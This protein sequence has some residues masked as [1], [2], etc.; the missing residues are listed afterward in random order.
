MKNIPILASFFFGLT[1]VWCLHM[2]F[3]TWWFPTY[4]FIREKLSS[5]ALQSNH[6]LY[7][8]SRCLLSQATCVLL[9]IAPNS[10]SEPGRQLIPFNPFW[11][12][13]NPG[14]D[15]RRGELFF[16]LFCFEINQHCLQHALSIFLCAFKEERRTEIDWQKLTGMFLADPKLSWCL[17]DSWQGCH[18]SQQP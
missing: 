6:L 7:F 15:G 9:Q 2:L 1:L 10:E 17:A 18:T 3:C 14:I 4:L 13:Q 12:F 5:T 16:P 8:S 11:G